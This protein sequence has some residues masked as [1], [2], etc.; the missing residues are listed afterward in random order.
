MGRFLVILVVEV[1]ISYLR[2]KASSKVSS[3]S[4]E[5]GYFVRVDT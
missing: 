2:S 4:I 5:S 1:E 3:L